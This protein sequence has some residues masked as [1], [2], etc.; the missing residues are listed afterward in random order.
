MRSGRFFALFRKINLFVDLGDEVFECHQF[1]LR[2]DV[3]VFF[4]KHLLLRDLVTARFYSLTYSLLGFIFCE[5]RICLKTMKTTAIIA[6]QGF[7]IF[8][9]MN[10]R[11][12]GGSDLQNAVGTGIASS[13]GFCLTALPNRFTV[14]V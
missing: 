14:R 13:D 10:W 7:V 11:R 3:G 12:S 6:S 9:E 8:I 2:T 4:E 5:M 1:Q